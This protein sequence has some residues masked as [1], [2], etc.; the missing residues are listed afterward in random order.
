MNIRTLDG[1]NLGPGSP[2]KSSCRFGVLLM[3]SRILDGMNL[4]PGSPR[5]SSCRKESK[6]NIYNPGEA[7]ADFGYHGT[8]T[9][10]FILVT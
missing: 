1:M 2:R 8:F 5:K 9:W 3:N 10:H 7:L 4:G 6:E